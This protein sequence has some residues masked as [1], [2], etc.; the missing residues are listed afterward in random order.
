MYSTVRLLPGP[1]LPPNGP[2]YFCC[3]Q[4]YSRA[5]PHGTGLAAVTSQALSCQTCWASAAQ[6]PTGHS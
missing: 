4:D 1:H 3:V 6:N 2:A 5:Q